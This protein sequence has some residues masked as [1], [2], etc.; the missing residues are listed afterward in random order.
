M[1]IPEA[2]LGATFADWRPA[3]ARRVADGRTVN[4]TDVVE[5]ERRVLGV[6]AGVSLMVQVRVILDRLRF[7]IVRK[8]VSW[9]APPFFTVHG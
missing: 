2:F 8:D 7:R 1:R 9:Q 3:A 4:A 6:V 5:L